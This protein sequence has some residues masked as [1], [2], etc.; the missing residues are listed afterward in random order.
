MRGT[1]KE[2]YVGSGHNKGCARYYVCTLARGVQSSFFFVRDRRRRTVFL[3]R[4]RTYIVSLLLF[5]SQKWPFGKDLEWL[6]KLA[7]T[8]QG[9][10]VYMSS[11][12][13]AAIGE[14]L[15]CEFDLSSNFNV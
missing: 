13:I 10:P 8:G 5:C 1:D 2:R 4:L 14:V 3:T 6:C 11:M 9:I 15:N 12:A 7:Q